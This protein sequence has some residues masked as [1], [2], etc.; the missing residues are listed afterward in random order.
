MVGIPDE[1]LG[2]A[3]KAWVALRDD[4]GADG[5]ARLD[6]KAVQRHCAAHLEDFAVPKHIEIVSELPKN[7][8]GK[9]DKLALMSA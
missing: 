5:E 6:V 7:Q 3:V 8:N 4:P 9:I 2:Q 1:L